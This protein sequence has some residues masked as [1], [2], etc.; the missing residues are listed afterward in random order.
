MKL[1]KRFFAEGNRLYYIEGKRELP[2]SPLRLDAP[3][4][5][6]ARAAGGPLPGDPASL[7]LLE[8]PWAQ[9]GSEVSGYNEEFLAAFRDFLKE[10]EAAG[11]YAAIVPLAGNDAFADVSAGEGKEALT[12]SFK[13]CA[14]RIKDCA[15]VAGFAVP[16][17]LS[18]A[19]AD[20][21]M[22]ELSA[23]HEQYVFF[24]CDPE[25]LKNSKIVKIPSK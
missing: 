18:G 17:C 7:L 22:E 12:A 8:L 21:F 1:E 9:V 20:C 10:L 2:V 19:E 6:A 4:C 5:V 13:H 24:S 25:Q 23:K 14:R 16:D 11:R 3:A 15:S